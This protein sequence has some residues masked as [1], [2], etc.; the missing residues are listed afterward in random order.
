MSRQFEYARPIPF[1]SLSLLLYFCIFVFLSFCIFERRD[2]RFEY[3]QPIP[4]PS[5]S[6]PRQD[7]GMQLHRNAVKPLRQD[8][9]YIKCKVANLHE[10]R[11]FRYKNWQRNY[12]GLGGPLFEHARLIPFP[13]L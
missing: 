11:H 10:N 13:S 3:A 4:F 9:L 8:Y 6:V 5:V 7:A 1:P 12:G 2:G